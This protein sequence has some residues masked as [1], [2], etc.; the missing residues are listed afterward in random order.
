[1]NDTFESCASVMRSRGYDLAATDLSKEKG[2]GLQRGALRRSRPR[3]D[4]AAMLWHRMTNPL[5]RGAAFRYV[6]FDASSQRGV[7]IF[8]SSERICTFDTE[9]FVTCQRR[10]LPLV[11]LGH[12]RVSLGDKLQAFVHQTWL[13]YG[14]FVKSVHV[15]N[16]AV[17]QCLSD[18]GTEF[19]LCDAR[20]VVPP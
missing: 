13:E 7:E 5:R 11:V 16:A 10:R 9:F 2:K 14:P 19:G 17:R 6:T 20:D 8:A 15:A 1:M 3:L 4:I 12:G 18:S